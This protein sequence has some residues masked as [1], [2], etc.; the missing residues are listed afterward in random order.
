MVL[1]PFAALRYKGVKIISLHRISAPAKS[2]K[3]KVEVLEVT[4]VPVMIIQL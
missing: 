4:A 3:G 1:N 2:L